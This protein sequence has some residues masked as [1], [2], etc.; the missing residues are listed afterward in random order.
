MPYSGPNVPGLKNVTT[1]EEDYL[2]KIVQGGYYG[3][4]N[5][6]RGEYVLDGGNP[7]GST[8]RTDIFSN[9]PVG[10]RP[11]VNYRGYVYDLGTFPSP[12][13]ILEY[14]GNA[15]GGKLNGKLLVANYSAGGNIV[16]LTRARTAA[17]RPS[18]PASPGS[19]ASTTR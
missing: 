11:D 15:F 6:T 7:G 8:G 9:Y 16:A 10:T 12:D 1:N 4:P 17:S 3:H 18:T 19:P 14:S 5:P 13:G 2:F